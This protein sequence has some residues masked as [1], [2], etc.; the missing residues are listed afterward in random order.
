MIESIVFPAIPEGEPNMVWSI[1]G[2]GYSA[3]VDKGNYVK[4]YFWDGI[5]LGW[6]RCDVYEKVAIKS[7]G[8]DAS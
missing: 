4:I 3:L 8:Q 7:G 2:G 5:A 6:I 1:G